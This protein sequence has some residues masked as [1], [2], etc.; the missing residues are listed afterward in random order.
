M[1]PQALHVRFLPSD[2]GSLKRVIG[3][4]NHIRFLAHFQPFD[5]QTIFSNGTVGLVLIG[6]S[7]GPTAQN[8]ARTALSGSTGLSV[9]MSRHGESRERLLPGLQTVNDFCF[10]LHTPLGV[11]VDVLAI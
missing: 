6:P 10:A 1:F 2:L 5:K 9:H 3:T 7:R 8:I 11:L 4:K